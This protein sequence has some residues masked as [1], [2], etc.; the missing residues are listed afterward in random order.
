MELTGKVALVTGAARGI[1]RAIA[2]ALARAGCDVA[3]SD[4]ARAE[5]GVTPYRLASDDDLAATAAAVERTGR[6][7]AA[8][9]ADVTVA[10]DVDAAH[11]VD[12]APLLQVSPAAH[13]RGAHAP[14]LTH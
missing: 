10:D 4:V 3:V 1:G 2:I 14:L 5:D 13:M 9:H 7:S 8:V 11:V 6:R 12:R